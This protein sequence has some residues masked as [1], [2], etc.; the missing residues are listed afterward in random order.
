MSFTA[1]D[2]TAQPKETKMFNFKITRHDDIHGDA[3]CFSV[4]DEDGHSLGRYPSEIE[5]IERLP[6]L[7]A[8]AEDESAFQSRERCGLR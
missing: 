8:L 7:E 5:A 4:V 6:Y 2:A 1:V 3:I